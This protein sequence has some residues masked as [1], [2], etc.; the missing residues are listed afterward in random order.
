MATKKEILAKR[1]E[2]ARVIVATKVKQIEL[3]TGDKA[4]ASKMSSAL[5]HI[6]QNNNLIDCSVESIINVGYQIVQAGLN[7]NPLFGQ[8][9][10]VPF[11]IKGKNG[12]S[13]FTV[14][15]LQ[16]G[17]K[18]F[19]QLG[20]RAGWRFKAVPVFKCDT[21]DY[22]FGGFEDEILLE[23]N[24][25]K[26]EEDDGSWVFT[27]LIGVIIYAKDKTNHISTEF[28]P[29]KKL[30]QL[31]CKSQN[32]V[33]GKLQHIWDTWAIEMYNAK[34]IKHI[35]SRLPIEDEVTEFLA[36]ENAPY[37]IE[38]KPQDKNRNN[39]SILTIENI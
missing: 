6:S 26:R 21:F 18:G 15:Q 22:K 9:Y 25:D 32:Q 37:T 4:K 31:R 7:P 1:E 16:I 30:E 23:P 5:V 20:Y 13:D 14:A 17:Y 29:F 36:V 35:V 27:N 12:N 10:V 24:F 11:K 8:A 38:S 28:V 34:A 2:E 33:T 19:I 3:I 39:N